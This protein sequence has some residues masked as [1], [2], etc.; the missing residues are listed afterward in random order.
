MFAAP[1]PSPPQ[2]ASGSVR[3]LAWL[4]RLVFAMVVMGGVFAT[5]SATPVA[6]DAEGGDLFEES[7]DGETVE[8]TAVDARTTRQVSAGGG[9]RSR[10]R[11]SVPQSLVPS[12][13][14]PVLPS[15]QRPRRVPPPDEDD[16]RA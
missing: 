6:G 5:A 15:W 8:E 10:E 4:T 13:A 2:T 16:A 9:R 11:L 14:A 3:L 7:E 1:K 12:V